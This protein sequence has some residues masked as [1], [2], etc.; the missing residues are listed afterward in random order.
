[1]VN[2]FQ[3]LVQALAV[4][5]A[6][7]A[8][9]VSVRGSVPREVGAKLVVDATG[10]AF[11]TI[12]GG[13]GEAK[14]LH[15]AEEVLKTGQKQR[16]EIDLSGA[17]QRQIEGICGGHMGVWL[18]RWQGEAARDLAKT[19]VQGLQEGRSLTLVTPFTTDQSP[20]LAETPIELAPEIAFVETLQPPPTLLIV[21]AGHVGI[22]LAKVAHLAGFQI[23]VQ[24]DRPEWANGELYPQASHVLAEPIEGAIAS[25]STHQTLYAALVT[26]GYIYDLEAL[27]H[28]LQRPIPCRYIGM[29]GSEK[30]VKQVYG[31]IAQTGLPTSKLAT[32][33]GPIGLDIGAL[34]PEEI[35]VSIVAELIMVQRGGTGRSL[36]EKLRRGM[37]GG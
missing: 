3:Q 19:I 17:P 37:G 5:P 30:R 11:G 34:T 29:I 14:V 35:A 12:G 33:Y 15:Q 31:A 13:A 24:D 26:R 36:S 21:G 4:G 32:V 9:V 22:Q 23:A 8:T 2:C 10:Q 1:M 16:V 25:L 6:V 28:L 18:E 27:Q 7:L 20:Y